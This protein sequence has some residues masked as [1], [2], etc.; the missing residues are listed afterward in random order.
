M[1]HASWRGASDIP[2]ALADDIVWISLPFLTA[3]EPRSRRT[4]LLVA[5]RASRPPC[6][7]A[8]AHEFRNTRAYARCLSN[9]RV[10]P[11]RRARTR[12][13]TGGETNP[14]VRNAARSC[15]HRKG[16]PCRGTFIGAVLI[17][18]PPIWR[19]SA[20]TSF[21]PEPLGLFSL[22]PRPLSAT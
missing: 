21:N 11:P 16:Q 22:I 3:R 4:P 9:N 1:G 7:V 2:A 14:T 19:A 13:R 8:K 15:D 18:G 5:H 17:D 10:I 6:R 20:A 12:A